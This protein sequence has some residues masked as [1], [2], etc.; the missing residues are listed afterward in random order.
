MLH[1]GAFYYHYLN[2]TINLFQGTVKKHGVYAA[3]TYLL[4]TK[5]RVLDRVRQQTQELPISLCKNMPKT[6]HYLQV[7]GAGG[8]RLEGAIMSQLRSGTTEVV[9]PDG[10]VSEW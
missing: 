1:L 9:A 10:Q 6:V 7:T 3:P 2:L 5:R 8:E 4:F